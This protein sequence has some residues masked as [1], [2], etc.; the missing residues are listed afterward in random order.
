MYRIFYN[1][2]RLTARR[3][4]VPF[5]IMSRT[6][7]RWIWLNFVIPFKVVKP[8]DNVT[9]NFV[10]FFSLFSLMV[11]M[12]GLVNWQRLIYTLIYQERSCTINSTLTHLAVHLL[13]RIYNGELVQIRSPTCFLSNVKVFA[14]LHIPTHYKRYVGNRS[15]IHCRTCWCK[16][17]IY[18][19]TLILRLRIYVG[20]AVANIMTVTC[21]VCHGNRSMQEACSVTQS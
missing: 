21:N 9:Y 15:N 8:S 16:C 5:G 6:S 10:R 18:V 2:T 17:N 20:M 7:P 1:V 13:D 14:I 12:L 4:A 11:I 3:T 19:Y